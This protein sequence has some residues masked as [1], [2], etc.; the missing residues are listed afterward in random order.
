[1]DKPQYFRPD[2]YMDFLLNPLFLHLQIQLKLFGL[3]T[4]LHRSAFRSQTGYCLNQ[5]SFHLQAVNPL[6]QDSVLTLPVFRR[7]KHHN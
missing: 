4:Y 1:M 3:L 2:K 7:K 6:N 5:D